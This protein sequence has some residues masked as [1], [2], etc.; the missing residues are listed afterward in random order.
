MGVDDELTML[1][2]RVVEDT[3]AIS[4]LLD[5]RHGSGTNT[6][7]RLSIAVNTCDTD[8]DM[9]SPSLIECGKLC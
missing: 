6:T 5:Q 1:A 9:Q 2:M 8:E 3:K 4:K 7:K